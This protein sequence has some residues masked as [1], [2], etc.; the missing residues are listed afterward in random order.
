MSLQPAVNY[1]GHRGPFFFSFHK[2]ILHGTR[3]D[4][5]L[6]ALEKYFLFRLSP[7]SLLALRI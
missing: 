1:H 5:I 6:L 3:K 7:Q 4:Y 2:S